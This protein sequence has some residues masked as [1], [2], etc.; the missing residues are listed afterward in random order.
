MD[1]RPSASVPARLDCP[2]RFW[3]VQDQTR[4]N[5]IDKINIIFPRR[6][7][8]STNNQYVGMIFPQL[9]VTPRLPDAGR[10]P[11]ASGSLELKNES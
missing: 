8:A 4:S 1:L 9:L 10:P 7:R 5:K 11:L 2:G 3:V 6:V